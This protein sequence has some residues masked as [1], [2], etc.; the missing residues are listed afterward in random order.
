[1]RKATTIIIVVII[2]LAAVGSIFW[3]LNK[4]GKRSV[5]EEKINE[6]GSVPILPQFGN[7]E[8]LA[9][10]DSKNQTEIKNQF[11]RVAE[12]EVSVETE[13]EKIKWF[14]LRDTSGKVIP[15]DNFLEANEAKIHP[16]IKELLAESD[17]EIFYCP[18]EKEKKDFGIVLY[19]S[20]TGF[21][22]GRYSDA[23]RY[24]REW[25]NTILSDFH[26]V[27]FPN[28]GFSPSDL[29][30]KLVFRDGKY[31]FAEVILPGEKK[32]SINYEN[33]GDAVVIATSME[34]L[35]IVSSIIAPL[36][37]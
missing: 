20:P 1:M 14:S 18:A 4:S 34:C 25:E 30:Q 33:F 8:T 24:L 36:Q 7:A 3:F 37:D 28:I 12:E 26:N 31:R 6:S 9:I 17:Y 29:R 13:R 19:V 5:S 21:Y 15:L 11:R 2:F 32:G 23:M 35:D 16:K 10:S 27:L 22:P